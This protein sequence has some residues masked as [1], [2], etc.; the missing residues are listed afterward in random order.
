M[1][2]RII[3][4]R[5]TAV[6][7]RASKAPYDARFLDSMSEHHRAAIDM[8]RLAQ[9][10][11]SRSEVKQLSQKIVAEQTKQIEQMKQMKPGKSG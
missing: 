4:A 1:P 7:P 10:K 9:A 8:A 2:A 6:R 3:P 11:A 5:R